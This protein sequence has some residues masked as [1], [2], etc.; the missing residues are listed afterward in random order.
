M[1]GFHRKLA[2][3]LKGFNPSIQVDANTTQAAR[4]IDALG[5]KSPTINVDVRVKQ[6]EASVAAA[7]RDIQSAEKNLVS[8]RAQSEDAAKRVEISEKALSETRAKSGENSSQAAA[9]ELKVSQARRNSSSAVNDLRNAESKLL[10]ARNN[11]SNKDTDL[12]NARSISNVS[13]DAGSAIKVLSKLGD[14]FGG[15]FKSAVSVGS[16]ASDAGGAFTKS[17]SE[18]VA[19]FGNVAGAASSAGGPILSL[20]AAALAIGAI[21]SVGAAAAA[22]IIGLADA[23]LTASGALLLIPGAL[24]VGGAGLAAIAVGTMGVSDAFDAMGKAQQSAV[25]DAEAAAKAQQAAADGVRSAE[26]G[27]SRA[28]ADA[29]TAADQASARVT[30]AKKQETR[31]VADAARAEVQAQRAVIDAE[32]A[33]NVALDDLAKAI[34]DANKAQRDLNLQLRGGALDASEAALNLADAQQTLSDA[35]AQGIGGA[36]LERYQIALKRAQLQVDQTA[37]SNS[38]LAAQQQAYATKGVQANDQV[39]AATDSVAR[40]EQQLADARDAQSYQA[41]QNAQRLADATDAVS[42]A[43]QAADQSALQSQRSITDAQTALAQAN[44]NA[45]D[46]MSQMSTSQQALNTALA[47]L[48]PNAKAFLD[49]VYALKPAWDRVQKSIQDALFSGLDK[50]LGILAD[51]YLP[52]VETGLGNIASAAN[53][54][55]KELVDLLIQPENKASINTVL[56]NTAGILRDL[57]KILTPL[58]SSFLDLADVGSGVLKD[59]VVPA[60]GDAVQAF[61]DWVKEMKD[62]GKLKDWMTGAVDTIKEVVGWVFKLTGAAVKV[63][64]SLAT[65]VKQSGFL[66]TLSNTLQKFV[67]WM[68][69]TEGQQFFFELGVVIG[70][71]GRMVLWVIEGLGWLI[72]TIQSAITWFTNLLK[73]W[74]WASIQ[75]GF[76]DGIWGI[77]QGILNAIGLGWVP[78]AL[79]GM[80]NIDWASIWGWFSTGIGQLFV[81]IVGFILPSPVRQFLEAMFDIDWSSVWKWFSDGVK[82][83]LRTIGKVITDNPLGQVLGFIFSNQSANPAAGG[84]LFAPGFTNPLGNADGGYISGPGG[85]RDDVIPSLLSNGEFVV[86]AASTA[87]NR[88]LLEQLNRNK[89]ADGGLVGTGAAGAVAGANTSLTIDV[90][91]L[92]N[93]GDVAATVTALVAALNAQLAL[94]VADTVA[95]WLQITTATA[96]ADT[97]I[98][99]SQTL[100][101]QQTAYSWATIQTAVWASTNGQLAAINALLVGLSSL[102]AAMAATGDWAVSQFGRISAAAADPI[103][104]VLNGPFNAGLIT[105]W[106]QLNTDF[107]LGQP[108]A[109][110]PVAFASG[111][112]VSGPG[113]DT[114]DSIAALLSNN[115]FVVRAKIAKRARPFLDALNA[116]QPEA[117]EAAGI[118]RFAT[119]G[120]VTADTGSQLNATV[121]RGQQF[122]RAQAGKPYVW[123]GVGPYGY[124]CSGLVSAVTNVLRGATN[125]YTRL[126]TAASQPWGGFVP[127]LSSAFATGYNGSH[128]ALTLGGLN[129]EAQ[130]FG[131]PVLVGGRAAGA[132]S[133]QFTGRASLPVVGGQFVPG[134]GPGADPNSIMAAA[135]A[136]TLARTNTI[137]D[138]W[139]GN[140]A[141]TA[142]SG[143]MHQAIDALSKVGVDKLTAMLGSTSIAIAGSPEVIAAVRAVAQAFGW[144][145][146]SEWAALQQLI[147]HESGWDPTIFNPKSSAGGL[148]QKM[149]SIHGALE[150]TIQG[151]SQW[152][153]NYIKGKYG[154]PISA[155]AAW[156]SRS[157]HWYDAGGLANGIGFMAK[158]TLEPERVL[159]PPQTRAFEAAMARVGRDSGQ[160]AVR[161]RSYGNDGVVVNQTIN[162]APGMDESALGRNASRYVVHSLRKL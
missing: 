22:S 151:Q 77:I 160:L 62:S 90:G 138:M 35:T 51:N 63:I 156:Q 48:S 127:G 50:Q 159:S 68:N 43:Q 73:G 80:F 60:I 67:D 93:L 47:A 11:K 34:S 64:G 88:G 111:G 149:T 95:Y 45:A 82:G 116:G 33:R 12:F 113:T 157:P 59:T 115:E 106:N 122:L 79:K 118:R 72:G 57:G 53:D 161:D 70:V 96:A 137:A 18:G 44:R 7:L 154:D 108:V 52:L 89:Y 132:D 54:A 61:A 124:D 9:A 129:G 17:G 145:E 110:V 66:D 56:E 85:P 8:S 144:G 65:G 104:Y 121:V 74:D 3:D 100:L 102:R 131:V 4:K 39:A 38:D 105:A 94:L 40:A 150:P 58:V 25:K 69:T 29:A 42:A 139:P 28:R 162:P 19:A 123:G 147:Q 143:M 158:N 112:F 92:A 128:T 134:G 101:Q 155:W 97:A 148:F 153:L 141:A 55:A 84:N 86:N 27:L 31:A 99:A 109:P 117:L 103:R 119:G 91:S 14:T 2:A 15:L 21:V 87:K 107:A 26:L 136:D 13:N 30:D 5:R 49:Q 36:E 1:A 76:S 32:K 41:Q 83:I 125:P 16:A 10:A 23:A 20:V 24:A 130:T 78:D 135:F 6:A 126:G 120:A 71:L 81:N 142:G 46:A 37:A 133:G 152:G 146:G 98:A 140:R 114:S 75:K